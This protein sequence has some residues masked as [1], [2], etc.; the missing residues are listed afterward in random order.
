VQDEVRATKALLLGHKGGGGGKDGGGKKKD[1]DGGGGSKKKDAELSTVPVLYPHERLC[2]GGAGA[3]LTSMPTSELTNATAHMFNTLLETDD[4]GRYLHV[5][6]ASPP[7]V[8]RRSRGGDGGRGSSVPPRRSSLVVKDGSLV[9]YSNVEENGAPTDRS[10][11]EWSP[12]LQQPSGS[13]SS[14]GSFLFMA[15]DGNLR[16]LA[17]TP[18]RPKHVLWESATGAHPGAVAVVHPSGILAV[19]PGTHPLVAHLD[20]KKAG[21]HLTWRYLDIP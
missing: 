20:S 1:A 16:L 3:A 11:I 17:G 7:V 13:G 10:D 2:G 8:R 15:P 4:A 18:Q 9:L 14:Q 21:A 6:W 5:L 12:V 19:V